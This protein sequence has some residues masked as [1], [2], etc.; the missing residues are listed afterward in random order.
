MSEDVDWDVAEHMEML[1]DELEAMTKERDELHAMLARAVAG[2]DLE[3]DGPNL[4]ARTGP[5]CGAKSPG[6]MT[7]FARAYGHGEMHEAHTICGTFTWPKA[8]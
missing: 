4:L 7:C 1:G 3:S 8:R 5:R 6:G 2:E